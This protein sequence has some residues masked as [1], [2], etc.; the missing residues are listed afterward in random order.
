MDSVSGDGVNTYVVSKAIK[1]NNITVALSGAG[2]DELFAGYPIFRQYLKLMKYKRAWKTSL[3]ARRLFSA[4][5]M[6]SRASR[7]QRLRQF[8]S[9]EAADISHFYPVFR[10]I[11]PHSMFAECVNLPADNVSLL[12][13]SF[14]LLQ[15]EINSLPLLGQVSAAEYSGYTKNTLL[16]DLDQMSMAVSLEVREPFFD[17]E[18][19][20]FVMHVPDSQ[21]FPSYPKKLLVEALDNLLPAEIIHRKKQGFLFPWNEWMKKDLASFSEKYI[22]DISKRDFINEKMLFSYWKRFL[23]NDSSVRWMELWLFIVLEYW[24]QK[25]DVR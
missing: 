18:L 8:L 10:Q 4:A 13:S 20:Q 16:K 23:A 21:K 1:K 2:G 3:P 6:G 7:N 12:T 22:T 24:L 5:L 15:E 9:A 25:N 17:H 11:V 14:Y 19:V